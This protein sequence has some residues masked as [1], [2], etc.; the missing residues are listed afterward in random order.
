MWPDVGYLVFL[1]EAKKGSGSA[2]NTVHILDFV[3]PLFKIHQPPFEEKS[4]LKQNLFQ[5]V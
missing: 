3:N 2:L 4:C 1:V 5:S